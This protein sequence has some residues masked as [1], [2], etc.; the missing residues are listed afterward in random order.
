MHG[1]MKNILEYNEI[2]LVIFYGLSVKTGMGESGNGIR[3]I[4]GTQVIG[5]GTRGIRV[6]RRG[7][8]VGRGGIRVGLRGIRV[9]MREIRV[10]LCEN[11]RVNCF[12]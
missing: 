2:L 5:V 8:K 12:G 10:I 7:V 6:G 3:G 1:I 9:R 11:L 4:M